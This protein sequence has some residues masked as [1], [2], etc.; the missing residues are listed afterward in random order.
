MTG[1]D[2]WYRLINHGVSRHEIGKK[3]T[4]FL[5][6]SVEVEKPQANER[7]A[8]LDCGKRES[9]LMNQFPD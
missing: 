3:P 7:K 6:W 1:V 8:P 4:E 2:L 5:V 9:W